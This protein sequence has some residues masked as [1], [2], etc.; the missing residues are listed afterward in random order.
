M[1]RFVGFRNPFGVDCARA[2][3]PGAARLW[4][5]C[6]QLHPFTPPGYRQGG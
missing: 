3:G 1:T 5:V 6:P 2:A 4:R